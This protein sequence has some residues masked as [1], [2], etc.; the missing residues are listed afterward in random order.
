M[1]LRIQLTHKAPLGQHQETCDNNSRRRYRKSYLALEIGT[2]STVTNT[3]IDLGLE[4]STLK[5]DLIAGESPTRSRHNI[6]KVELLHL[7]CH[8]H[9]GQ[10]QN[11]DTEN[12][13]CLHGNVSEC[14]DWKMSKNLRADVT[15]TPSPPA[16]PPKQ[17][18][19]TDQIGACR[20]DRGKQ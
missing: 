17:V 8:G 18:C 13:A 19:L 20:S 15:S 14:Q 6:P 4:V 12:W 3:D 10:R 7:V 9:T 2:T 11:S 1:G 16:S 5:E